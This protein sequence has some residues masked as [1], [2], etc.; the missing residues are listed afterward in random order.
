MRSTSSSGPSER[1]L[2]FMI[3]T[4]RLGSC[5]ATCEFNLPDDLQPRFAYLRGQRRQETSIHTFG[6]LKVRKKTVY[7][8]PL[9]VC[10]PLTVHRASRLRELHCN[11]R[12]AIR[13]RIAL[14][15]VL[16][17][18][19]ALSSTAT[20]HSNSRVH[21]GCVQCLWTVASLLIHCTHVSASGLLAEPGEPGGE[22]RT[23]GV[24]ESPPPD[25]AT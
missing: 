13:V 3:A 4:C 16:R 6:A 21:N 19:T 15:Y 5:R 8:G 25:A 7:S 14:D 11:S 20:Q 22:R 9:S 12:F 23:P 10:A 24:A 17:S 2:A 18:H 1:S